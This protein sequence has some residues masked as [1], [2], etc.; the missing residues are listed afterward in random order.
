ME[1]TASGD[2]A[3]YWGQI[4]YIITQKN[5][6]KKRRAVFWYET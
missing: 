6:E 5:A 1:C 4:L 3:G 2:D